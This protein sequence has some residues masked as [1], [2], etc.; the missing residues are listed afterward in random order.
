M[1]NRIA[2][3]RKPLGLS[4][5]R[6]AKLVGL[7]RHSIMAYENQAKVPALKIAYEISKV[8]K[9]DIKEIFMLE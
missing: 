2:E 5:H 6:L 9:K 1:N 8:L 3:F 7:K 4:Q